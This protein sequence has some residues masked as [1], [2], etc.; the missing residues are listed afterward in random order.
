MRKMPRPFIRMLIACFFFLA[1]VTLYILLP[2]Y[3]HNIPDIIKHLLL[4]LS[5]VMCIHI[6]EYA[7]FWWEI[8][9]H[10]KSI[11]QKL[12]T[13]CIPQFQLICVI[14]RY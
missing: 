12:Y 10:M 4:A 8:Y 2:R 6:I 5:A 14:E 1:T 7:F 13:F 3:W 9:G 11:F